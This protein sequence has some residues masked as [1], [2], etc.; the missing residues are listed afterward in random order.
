MERSGGQR[1]GQGGLEFW[2]EV[3]VEK[4]DAEVDGLEDYMG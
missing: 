3:W 2:G 1:R 4:W